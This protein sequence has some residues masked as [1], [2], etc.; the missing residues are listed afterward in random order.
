MGGGEEVPGGGVADGAV[1]E[2]VVGVD[3]V[4]EVG[5][6][7]AELDGDEAGV[8]GLVLP[9]VGTLAWDG[10]VGGGGGVAPLE[11]V[12]VGGGAEGGAVEEGEF[13]ESLLR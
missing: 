4:L 6:V 10:A 11:L 8:H 9:G 3:V 12:L 5:A 2:G 13:S 1:A 7:E